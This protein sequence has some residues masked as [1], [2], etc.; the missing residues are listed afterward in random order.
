MT[1]VRGL[2][3]EVAGVVGGLTSLDWGVGPVSG[4]AISRHGLGHVKAVHITSAC[5][6]DVDTGAINL[7]YFSDNARY[8]DGRPLGRM[9]GRR[10]A[11]LGMFT[12]V[13]AR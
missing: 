1:T 2:D 12:Q 5:Q 13:S 9:A 7:A 8:I 4:I 10:I 6:R 11:Q 3:K